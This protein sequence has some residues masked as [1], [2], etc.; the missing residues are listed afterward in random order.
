MA[1]GEQMG[2]EHIPRGFFA[3]SRGNWGPNQ[4]FSD[5]WTNYPQGH[6]QMQEEY[7]GEQ[8][9]AAKL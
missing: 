7:N 5:K 2:V 8:K 3:I 4:L 9:I 6:S 1:S